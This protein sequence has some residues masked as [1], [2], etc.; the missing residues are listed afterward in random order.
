MNDENY[1]QNTN[2]Y[3]KDF[4]TGCLALILIFVIFFLLIPISIFVLKLSMIL[5]FPIAAFILLIIFTLF[6]GRIINTVITVIK[7]E[8]NKT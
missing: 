5:V 6:F 8:K 3:G 2:R 7:K 1:N 4:L